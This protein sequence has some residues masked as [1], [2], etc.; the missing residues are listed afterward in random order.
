MLLGSQELY[1]GVKEHVSDPRN[2][3]QERKADTQSCEAH[4]SESKSGLVTRRV[5]FSSL[6]KIGAL[7]FSH[8][9]T[10]G[11]LEYQD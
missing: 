2:S 6:C 7:G 3:L 8:G 11:C 1:Y 5:F 9:L 4:H 10:Y